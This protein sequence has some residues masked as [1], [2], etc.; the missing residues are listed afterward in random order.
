MMHAMRRRHQKNHGSA[1]RAIPFRRILAGYGP[2]PF[3]TK[4]FDGQP[5]HVKGVEQWH[6]PRNPDYRL[7]SLIEKTIQ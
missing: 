6:V 2:N 4:T 3:Y 7:C 5:F 1:H